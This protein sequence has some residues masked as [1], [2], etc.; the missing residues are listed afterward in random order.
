MRKRAG[1]VIIQKGKIALIK[2][3]KNDEIYYVIPG[4]QKEVGETLQ[5]AAKREAKEELGVEVKIGAQILKVDFNG[6]QYYFKATITGGYFGSGG[7]EEFLRAEEFGS[8]EAVWVPLD[9]LYLHDIRPNEILDY[10][11]NSSLN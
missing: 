4:G 8:Y 7:G 1:V 3:V 2:R 10:I 11:K 6:Q 5:Q 9:K